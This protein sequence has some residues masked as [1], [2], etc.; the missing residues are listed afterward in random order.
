M[1]RAGPYCDVMLSLELDTAL[2]LPHTTNDITAA[3]TQHVAVPLA[4]HHFS[5]TSYHVTIFSISSN[6]CAPHLG[7]EQ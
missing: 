4:L 1:M 5:I 2:P 3:H 7:L 6:G